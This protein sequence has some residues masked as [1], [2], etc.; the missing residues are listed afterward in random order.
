MDGDNVVSGTKITY[1]IG[2]DRFHVENSKVILK[3]KKER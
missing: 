3:S 1:F 2:N